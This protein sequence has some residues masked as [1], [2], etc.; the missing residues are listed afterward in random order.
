MSAATDKIE[1]LLDDK[2]HEIHSIG[3]DATVLDAVD[4]MCERRI[5]ALLVATTQATLGILSERD[6]LKR[7]ILEGREP[8]QTCVED[9]M[10]RAVACVHDTTP[11]GD[12]MAIMTERRCRHLPV[13]AHG[14]VVGIVS[15]GDIVRWLSREQETEIRMLTGYV[16]G[17]C[18]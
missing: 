8:D 18:R 10:T 12:A 5:G 6:V 14:A 3:P 15:I 9:V 17:E 1:D 7:V 4:M 2:G 13:V 16:R 11:V